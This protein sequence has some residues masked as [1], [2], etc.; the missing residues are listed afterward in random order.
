MQDDIHDQLVQAYLEYFA[1]NEI[2]E[3]KKSVRSYAIVQQCIRK[4]RTLADK[5]NKEIRH[6]HQTRK[7]KK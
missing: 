7:D 4:V 5:R 6:I 3:R 2:W 1:A